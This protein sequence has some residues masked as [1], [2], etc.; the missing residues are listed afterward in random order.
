[1]SD[2]GYFRD[3]EY[4]SMK[5]TRTV[6]DDTRE[7]LPRKKAQP[8]QYC[9]LHLCIEDSGRGMD[10]LW[11]IREHHVIEGLNLVGITTLKGKN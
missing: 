7:I 4:V 6:S 8:I 9:Q 10:P 3:P 2:I 1:M 11:D 5:E